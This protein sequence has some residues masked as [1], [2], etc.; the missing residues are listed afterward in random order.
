[1]K[2]TNVLLLVLG[3]GVLY[4]VYASQKKTTPVVVTG[5]GAG[6]GTNP[7]GAPKSSDPNAYTK[8]IP[9][10][11]NTIENLFGPQD[12]TDS[13]SDFTDSGN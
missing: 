13:G 11:L 9:D 8:Y 12:S 1:M 7:T 4:Y 5:I 2:T 6:Q 10:V 3:A